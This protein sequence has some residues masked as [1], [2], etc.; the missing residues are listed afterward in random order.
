MQTSSVPNFP[1]RL[2][3]PWSALY[4]RKSRGGTRFFGGGIFLAAAAIAPFIW[5]CRICIMLY[6]TAIWGTWVYL[7]CC[8][9]LIIAAYVY[10]AALIIYAINRYRRNVS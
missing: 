4:R 9:W 1:V 2:I 10:L 3:R 5:L 8:T 6:G 7:V